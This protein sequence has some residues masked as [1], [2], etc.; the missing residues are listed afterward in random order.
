MQANITEIFSSIQGEGPYIG[1]RQIFVRFS[2]CNLRCEYCDTDHRPVK[3]LTCEELLQ[4]INS[5]NIISHHSISLTGGEPLVHSD[6][7]SEFLPMLSDLKV[8][9]ETNGVLY[10]EFRKIAPYVDIISMDIKIES[11]TG[12]QLPFEAHEEFIKVAR[13]FKKEIFAKVVVS[14]NITD[15]EIRLIKYLVKDDMMLVLQ[16]M[17]NKCP[18]DKLI[19]IQMNFLKDIKDVRVIPQVHKYMGLM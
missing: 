15:E 18:A 11:S 7:L 17:D 3:M 10:N 19:S 12:Q 14:E 9:L 2:G 4:E 8:Y 16:P 13:F 5:L 1:C 6:F